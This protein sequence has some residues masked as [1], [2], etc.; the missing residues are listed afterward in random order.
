MKEV[1]CTAVILAA[2]SGSR[3]KSNVAKQFLELKGKP[4][5][6]YVL[7]AF[8]ESE[9][10]DECVLVT[11]QD[12]LERVRREIVERYCF[13]KVKAV[14]AGGAERCFSV[15]NAMEWLAAK[16]TAPG[17]R[18]YIFIH[19]GARPF[20]T[21]DILNR[22]FQGV[23]E[24]GAC[25]AAMPSKD[26]VKLADRE[27][28]AEQT[29]ERKRVWTVQTPQVFEKSLITEAYRKFTEAAAE[30][31]GTPVTDDAGVVERFSNRKVR[32]VEGSYR[33]IKVTT[34]E[35]M[36]IAEAFLESIEK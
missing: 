36:L 25:V 2:G 35:D 26:T 34:P 12:D 16:K 9:F 29:P 1:K 8:D 3:M 7:K 14:L 19:D 22:V 30:E 11:G 33:N 28:Y 21:Q 20:L 32:L 24:C 23:L 18:E 6:Y 27:G 15:A 10:I 31:S 17:V 13:R 5:I 4:L